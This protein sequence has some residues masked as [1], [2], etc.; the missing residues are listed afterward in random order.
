[1]DRLTLGDNS[2]CIIDISSQL[3]LMDD[4]CDSKTER[5]STGL[6]RVRSSGSLKKK[7]ALKAKI[8]ELEDKLNLMDL[9]N[10]SLQ[11]NLKKSFLK[12][13]HINNEKKNNEA[14]NRKKMLL[15]S[16]S[17]PKAIEEA[18]LQF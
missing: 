17:D 6:T 7:K 9:E 3:K 2:L 5:Q 18:R 11:N 12:S 14:V 10:A 13:I 4:E 15:K 8:K 16:K 1:M